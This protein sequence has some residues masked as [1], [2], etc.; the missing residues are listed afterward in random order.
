MSDRILDNM[1]DSSCD[2]VRA[3]T[4]VVAS[5]AVAIE[6][7]KERLVERMPDRRQIIVA[8]IWKCTRAGGPRD[9]EIFSMRRIPATF[10]G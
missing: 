9:L 3:S 7:R 5:L 1:G 10:E 2:P 4:V 6:Y 8:G